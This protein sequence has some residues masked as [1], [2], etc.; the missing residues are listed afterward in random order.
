MFYLKDKEKIFDRAFQD[1]LTRPRTFH[2]KDKSGKLV[3]KIFE[4]F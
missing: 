2:P 4:A 1:S 3:I